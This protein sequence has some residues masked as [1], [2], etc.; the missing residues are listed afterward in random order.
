[1]SMTEEREAAYER[2]RAEV[3]RP[4]LHRRIHY[5]LRLL[6]DPILATPCFELASLDELPKELLDVMV[7]TCS[8]P[9]YGL[10]PGIGLAANQVGSLAAVCIVAKDGKNTGEYHTLINPRLTHRSETMTWRLEGCLSIPGFTTSVKRHDEVTVEF[11]DTEWNEQTLTVSGLTAQ[12]VQHELDH[13][14]GKTILDGLSRQQRR[15]AE[16]QVA[17]AVARV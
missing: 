3:P 12:A 17:A 8:T 14:S 1:M 10:P 2:F 16:R 5:R 11:R 9:R 6:D 13:L 15:N 4:S 7:Q